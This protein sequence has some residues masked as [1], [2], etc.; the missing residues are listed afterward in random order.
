M[1]ITPLS[2]FLVKADQFC[3]YVPVLSTVS[4]LIDLFI[5]NIIMPRTEQSDIDQSH[6]YSYLK[7]KQ[8]K[9]LITYAIPVVG[10]AVAIPIF[11]SFLIIIVFT[12]N[13]ILLIWLKL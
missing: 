2:G 5:I 3:D 10:N 7:Q 9:N 8:W 4:N 1:N 12:F 13:H 6:Y 11:K